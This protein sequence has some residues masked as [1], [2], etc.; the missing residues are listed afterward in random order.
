MAAPRVVY[1][2]TA[3]AMVPRVRVLTDVSAF[4]G[5]TNADIIAIGDQV[6]AGEL[7][8][9]FSTFVGDEP[10]MPE[11]GCDI[12][13]RAFQPINGRL[14]QQMITDAYL[15]ARRWVTDAPVVPGAC[16]IIAMPGHR[17]AGIVVGYRFQ[18]DTWHLP[19]HLV[20]IG[21]G[22]E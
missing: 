3:M 11:F 1:R 10:G 20:E 7:Y 22:N 17:V 12:P 15:S 13:K 18:G 9:L 4:Y 19:V 8:N 14:A 16:S 6:R 5:V 21:E 2:T